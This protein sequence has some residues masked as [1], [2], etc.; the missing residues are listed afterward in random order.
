MNDLPRQGR[1]IMNE[2]NACA[3]CG[4]QVTTRTCI[5]GFTGF[6]NEDGEE[7]T[8]ARE[9]ILV[10]HPECYMRLTREESFALLDSKLNPQAEEEQR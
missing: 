2:A 10:L 1:E 4:E 7:E 3:V 8:A 5:R 6:V 9:T